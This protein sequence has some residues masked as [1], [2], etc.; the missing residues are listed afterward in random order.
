MHYASTAA[1][2][3]RSPTVGDTRGLGSGEGIPPHTRMDNK[4]KILIPA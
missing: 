1:H 3:I 2:G 4:E